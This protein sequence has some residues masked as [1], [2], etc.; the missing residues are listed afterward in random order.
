M[1]APIIFMA[2]IAIL[3]WG[4]AGLHVNF[5]KCIQKYLIDLSVPNFNITDCLSFFINCFYDL[6]FVSISLLGNEA[7]QIAIPLPKIS[8]YYL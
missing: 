2:D 1:M 8:F 5:H 3:E 7:F 4:K 6:G